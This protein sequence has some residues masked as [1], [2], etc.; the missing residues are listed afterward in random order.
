[1]KFKALAL[2]LALFSLQSVQ[3]QDVVEVKISDENCSAITVF[4]KSFIV[5]I[6]KKY[7]VSY[8]S[9]RLLRTDFS[10]RFRCQATFNTAK[11]P[12]TCA[13]G[14]IYKVKGRNG[15]VGNSVAYLCD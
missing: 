1:M 15:L 13:V 11:G 3:A 6:A 10:S 7:E 14:Q 9:V 4:T 5:D 8:D 2:S 12:K